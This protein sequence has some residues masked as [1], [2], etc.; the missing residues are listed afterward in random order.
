MGSGAPRHSDSNR[1]IKVFLDRKTMHPV[2]TG[3]KH[4]H[5]NETVCFQNKY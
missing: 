3:E 4:G 2:N 1:D 5:E